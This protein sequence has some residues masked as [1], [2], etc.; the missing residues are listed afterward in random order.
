MNAGRGK[1]VDE[2]VIPVALNNGWLSGAALDV[3]EVEPLPASSPL[4]DDRRVMVSPHISG[5][6]TSKGAIGGF[7]ECVAELTR[8]ELPGRTVD[9]TRQY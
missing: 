5:I 7:M 6:T 3:F 9:R 4:W 8:G 1:L 2:R